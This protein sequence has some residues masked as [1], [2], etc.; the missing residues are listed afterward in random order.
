MSAVTL[1]DVHKRYSDSADSGGVFGVTCEVPEGCLATLLGPSGSGKTTLLRLLAGFLRPTYGEIH[2]GDRVVAGPRTFVPPNARDLAMVFQSYALW[3]HMSVFENVAFGL[4]AR[5][6]DRSETAD[7]VAEVLEQVGLGGY[8][9]R[10][11]GEL[12]GGQQQRVALARSVVLR[13]RLLLLDEPLSNLDADRRIRMRTQL[14]ELQAATGITFVYVTHDQDEALALSDHLL[15]LENGRV[16]QQG[17]PE[18]LY[19]RPANPRVARFLARG[20][21]YLPGTTGDVSGNGIAFIPD[22]RVAGDP[23][24]ATSPTPEPAPSGEAAELV[25]RAECVHLLTE[26]EPEPAEIQLLHGHVRTVGFAGRENHVDV[27]LADG[28]VATLTDTYRR[29]LTAGDPVRVGFRPDDALVLLPTEPSPHAQTEH[30]P[31]EESRA[32]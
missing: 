17:P 13:P 3:P 12:S 21:L 14:K 29:P 11:P 28:T 24:I 27:A 30:A 26:D 15:V 4:R 5:K 25:V 6:V 23:L 18:D 22:P 7:R 32:Q 31:L 19:A 9:Q 16:L 1:N 2:I 8:G 20:G 10:K